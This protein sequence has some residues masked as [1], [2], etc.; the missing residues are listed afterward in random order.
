MDHMFYA[1]NTNRRKQSPP[2]PIVV[3][4][5]ASGKP[6]RKNMGKRKT[7][8][9]RVTYMQ[10]RRTVQTQIPTAVRVESILATISGSSPD[11]DD[12]E[13]LEIINNGLPNVKEG[14]PSDHLPIGALFVPD[15]N[16]EA[17]KEKHVDKSSLP[18]VDEGED[19]DGDDQKEDIDEQYTTTLD[20]MKSGL[21]TSA[22]RRRQAGAKSMSIRRRHNIV[23]GC[24]TEWLTECG[25]YD[26]HRD[27]P[28]YKLKFAQGLKKLKKKSRAPDLVC[29][30]GD[31][32][33]IVEVTVTNK[34]DSTRLAKLKKYEDL[35]TIV[36]SSPVVQDAG[37]TVQSPFVIL[38]DEQGGIPQ[39][40]QQ[41]VIDLMK[42]MGKSDESAQSDAQRFFNHL[43]GI[44]NEFQ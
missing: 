18:A 22:I 28:L 27:Q 15:K 16:F 25:A 37:L 12:E 32:L 31:S 5:A 13:R 44:F 14:F 1:Q 2:R 4:A 35:E 8:R 38:L 41:D 3:A 19:D 29:C 17:K 24:V 33:L 7:R 36:Q 9:Q 26:V 11:D 30:L 6:V 21:S 42:L 43:Q 10:K 20:P 34:P 40:T 23:L 39:E